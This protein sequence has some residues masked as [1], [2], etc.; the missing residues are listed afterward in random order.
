MDMTVVVRLLQEKYL[1]QYLYLYKAI[2]DFDNALD[3]D[4]RDL[5]WMLLTVIFIVCC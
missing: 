3:A 4:N 5:H 2:L 1:M